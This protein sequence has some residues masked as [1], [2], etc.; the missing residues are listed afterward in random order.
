MTIAVTGATGQLGRLIV[1]DLLSAG[2]AP[3][4][5]VATGR[6]TERLADLAAR[7]VRTTAV[8]YDDVE[9]LSSAFAG[10]ETVVLVS[11][12]DPG[13]RVAQHT[14]VVEAAKAAGVTRIVYTS[15]AHADTSEHALAPDHRA[16]EQVIRESGLA[17]TFLRNNWYTENQAPNV[18]QA[19]EHGA[20]VSSTG[21]G[22][23][24]SASRAD[25]AA[26]AAVVAREAGHEGRTYELTG[27]VAWTYDELAAA[28]EDV[29]GTPVVH[30]AVS[31]SEL[32]ATLADAG[33]DD[34]TIAFLVALDEGTARGDLAE[35]TADLRTLIGRPTTPLADTLR[36]L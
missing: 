28:L 18:A 19:R 32:A 16:T 30:K 21:T 13:R 8:G 33:L 10:V 24:A 14:T 2:T 31:P 22:R 34:G 17:W 26:A 3:D 20:I 12:T 23:T 27:D 7:G 5:I 6:N 4:E 11:G 36:A 1:E 15:I 25:Y 29:L 35:T 9:G